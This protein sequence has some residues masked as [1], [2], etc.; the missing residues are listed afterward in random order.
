MDIQKSIALASLAT[1]IFFLLAYF[2]DA[3]RRYMIGDPYFYV[4]FLYVLAG[5]AFLVYS[6]LLVYAA[7]SKKKN[8]IKSKKICF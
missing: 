4:G 6:S 7:F 8:I 3:R 2:F 1:A 5:F